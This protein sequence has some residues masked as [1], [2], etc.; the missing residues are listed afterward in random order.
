VSQNATAL[1]TSVV[2]AGRRYELAML[3]TRA[4]VVLTAV[5]LAILFLLDRVTL[6][7]ALVVLMIAFGATAILLV[8][9]GA[10]TAAGAGSREAVPVPRSVVKRGFF[11][12]GLSVSLSVM[13]ALDKV[14]IGKMMP[15]SEL[16]VYATVFAVMK[17]FDF[18]FYSISYVLMPHMSSIPSVSLRKYNVWLAGVAA[19]ILLLYVLLGGRIVHLLYE[20]RYDGGIYLILPFALSGVLK[21][22]YS[23]PSSIIG[24]RLPG[25]AL[26]QFLWFNMGGMAANVVLDIV[27]IRTMGLLGAAVATALAWGIRLAGSYAVLF[28][29]RPH[30]VTLP[31]GDREGLTA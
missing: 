29:N 13:V 23:L 28:F 3:G 12:L 16:A 18:V 25:R 6:N 19:G 22:F 30:L 15:Y 20:G 9:R 5:A 4:P 24:G 21:L 2:R 14:I 1:V 17:G 26:R 7:A 27:M 10:T 11:F 8:A 31:T